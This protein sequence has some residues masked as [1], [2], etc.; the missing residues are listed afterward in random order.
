MAAYVGTPAGGVLFS[1]EAF[2]TYYS[3]R[4][5]VKIAYVAIVAG[6]TTKAL[7]IWVNPKIRLIPPW[8]RSLY[9]PNSLF[10]LFT[11]SLLI[12]MMGFA[13]KLIVWLNERIL[14]LR[15]SWSKQQTHLYK[16]K[17]TKYGNSILNHFLQT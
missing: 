12:I 17:R 5:F 14:Y 1:L 11:F 16:Q 15:E 7:N 4:T 2:G 10:E 9:L 6:F 3:V 13:G 8:E